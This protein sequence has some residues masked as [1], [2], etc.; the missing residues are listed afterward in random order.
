[1]G[2]IFG[3]PNLN[4]EGTFVAAL[5]TRIDAGSNSSGSELFSAKGTATLDAHVEVLKS[6]LRQIGTICH[7]EFLSLFDHRVLYYTAARMWAC[8]GVSAGKDPFAWE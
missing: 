3:F 6:G 2:K 1:L 8:C 4:I 7:G 5:R